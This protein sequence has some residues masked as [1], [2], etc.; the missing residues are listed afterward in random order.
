M[1]GVREVP[2]REEVIRMVEEGMVEVG[3]G[4]GGEE[5]GVGYSENDD[6]EWEIMIREEEEKVKEELVDGL[7]GDLLQE[8][9]DFGVGLLAG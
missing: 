9:I 4:G 2:E 7:L 6:K 3:V 1:P 8:A 5:L